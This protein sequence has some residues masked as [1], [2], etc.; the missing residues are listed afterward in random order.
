M[1]FIFYLFFKYF[2]KNVSKSYFY[3]NKKLF[4]KE[5]SINLKDKVTIFR[6]N[7]LYLVNFKFK[8]KLHS[9]N[10]E[11]A[12][13]FVYN[14]LYKPNFIN[15]FKEE[16]I[17]L[18]NCD[19]L[20]LWFKN[21]EMHRD[22]DKYASIF[23]RVNKDIIYKWLKNNKLHR[24]TDKPSI[25]EGNNKYYYKN[26][27]L[28]RK[29]NYAVKECFYN[30]ITYKWYENNKLHRLNDPA[31][32]SFGQFDNLNS[33]FINGVQKSKNDLIQESIRLK[34]KSF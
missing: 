34:I 3:E 26:G 11:P 5:K 25:I 6:T 30:T 31:I 7:V 22:N 2:N 15:S 16:N 32:I 12:L 21:G 20:A 33:F 9:L 18:Y 27:Q 19:V 23:Y 10:D 8:E 17:H 29:D 4:K 28:H 24:D 14:E 13:L 1:Y